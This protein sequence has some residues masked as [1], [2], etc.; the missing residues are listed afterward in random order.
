MTNTPHLT[1]PAERD[2]EAILNQHLH[3]FV[4][5]PTAC[6]HVCLHGTMEI[7]TSGIDD[8][9]EA[10]SGGG[11]LRLVSCE[12]IHTVTAY[13]LEILISGFH[14]WYGDNFQQRNVTAE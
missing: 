12:L 10:G 1:T 9:S 13:S 8:H 7:N 4:P 3:I 6:P 2:H 5:S 14:V 11:Y